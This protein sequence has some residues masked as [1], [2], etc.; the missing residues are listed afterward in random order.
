M[1]SDQHLLALDGNWLVHRAYHQAQ[2]NELERASMLRVV[3]SQVLAQVFRYALRLSAT[4]IVLAFDDK[5]NFRKEIY[6]LYKAN[7]LNLPELSDI[8]LLT[9]DKARELMKLRLHLAKDY[10]ADDPVNE[11]RVATHEL[12]NKLGLYVVQPK[13]HEADD[14]LRSASSLVEKGAF[15]K[16]TNLTNDKDMIQGLAPGVQLYRPEMQK[17]PEVFTRFT[18]MKAHLKRAAG[19]KATKWSP[20]QF[21]DYQTL[22]GDPVDFIPRILPPSKAVTVVSKYGSLLAWS[23]TEEGCDF[24]RGNREWI[25]RNRQLVTMVDTLFD[26]CKDI[27]KLTVPAVNSL[28]QS[29]IPPSVAKS[30]SDYMSARKTFNRP[31]LF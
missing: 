31:K 2:R 14:V 23:K 21:L 11:C 8:K 1:S 10:T 22:V 27:R 16:V 5:E 18:D 25:H 7:R 19:D 13:K 12:A 4:N 29:G 26:D 28:H 24:F 6:P 3:S 9:L 17:Q 20:E 15:K 30:M